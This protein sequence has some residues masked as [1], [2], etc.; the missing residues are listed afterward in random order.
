MG[1]IRELER[2]AGLRVMKRGEEGVKIEEL[3]PLLT[4]KIQRPRPGLM[5]GNC[6]RRVFSPSVD[7]SGSSSH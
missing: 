4:P 6:A 3:S 5:T 1:G 2:A 7:E